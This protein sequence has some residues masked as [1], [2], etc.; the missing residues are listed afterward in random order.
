MSERQ[1]YLTDYETGERHP[2]SKEAWE[3]YKSW[4]AKVQPTL[5][6]GYKGQTIIGTMSN[7]EEGDI[8]ELWMGVDLARKD[9][10]VTTV[11]QLEEGRVARYFTPVYDQSF[12]E[13]GNPKK[14]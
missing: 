12:D 1:H 14:L 13:F 4:M 8:R 9:A 3:A 5:P 7:Y 6:N 10:D 11:V 2:V